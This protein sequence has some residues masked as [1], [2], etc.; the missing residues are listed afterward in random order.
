MVPFLN[1][2]KSFY[3]LQHPM[4]YGVPYSESMNNHYNKRYELMKVEIAKA[5][6]AGEFSSFVFMYERPYRLNAFVELIK[7]RVIKDADYWEILGSIWIDSENIWQNLEVWRHLLSSKRSHKRMFME[8]EDREALKKL[9]N[10]LTVYRGCTRGQN[11]SGMSWTLDKKRA[12]WFSSRFLRRDEK[13][14]VLEKTIN[15]NKVFAYLT[16]RNEE[17][18]IIL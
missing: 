8:A 2:G 17:E 5:L 6:E 14:V 11:E 16:G 10:Q 3:T 1:Q 4:V 18:I 15:K 13:A 12:K 7:S 9:P